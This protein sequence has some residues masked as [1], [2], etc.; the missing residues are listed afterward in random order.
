MTDS[1]ALNVIPV[2][3][4]KMNFVPGVAALVFVNEL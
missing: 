3:V 4:K 1:E 2:E